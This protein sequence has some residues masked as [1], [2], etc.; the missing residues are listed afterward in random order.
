MVKLPNF[1]ETTTFTTESA[2][3][4]KNLLVTSLAETMTSNH[5]FQY[6][7]ILGRPRVAIFSDIIKI[8]TM[9]IEI[10]LKC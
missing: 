3:R 8:V 6:T 9:F 2:S 5:L 7:F 1:G 10:I 4:N